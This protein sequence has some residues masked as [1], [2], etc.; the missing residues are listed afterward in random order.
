MELRCSSKLHGIL[1]DDGTIE[2]KCDSKFCGHAPGVVVLH[3]FNAQTGELVETLNFKNP[4][5]RERSTSDAHCNE[6]TAL[7]SEGR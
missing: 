1:R 5:Q 6:L 2:V 7:R 4:T 3:R